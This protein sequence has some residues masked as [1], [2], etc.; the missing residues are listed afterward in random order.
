MTT[1]TSLSSILSEP[2]HC[3]LLS[4]IVGWHLLPPISFYPLYSTMKLH[5]HGPIVCGGP[6]RSLTQLWPLTTVIM[7][8]SRIQSESILSCCLYLN[9]LPSKCSRMNNSANACEVYSSRPLLLQASAAFKANVCAYS[10]VR[11]GYKA[12]TVAVL[13]V[14]QSTSSSSAK[15]DVI[16]RIDLTRCIIW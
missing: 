5:T 2:S 12:I 9:Q 13:P 4:C 8:A 1:T 14:S 7:K 16:W 10:S 6:R 3:L 11:V 15:S